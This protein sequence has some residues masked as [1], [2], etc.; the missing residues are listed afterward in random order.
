LVLGLSIQIQWEGGYIAAGAYLSAGQ[1]VVGGASLVALDILEVDQT[2]GDGVIGHRRRKRIRFY[3]RMRHRAVVVRVSCAGRARM[4]G[5]GGI[6]APIRAERGVG[7][8]G[9]VVQGRVEGVA[10]RQR[11]SPCGEKGESQG[12]HVE[13]CLIDRGHGLGEAEIRTINREVL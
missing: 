10:G 11:G 1:N 5:R 2:R 4:A 6:Y 13:E 8:V 3:A 7:D 9:G 12:D